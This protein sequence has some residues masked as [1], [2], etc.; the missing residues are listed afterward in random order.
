MGLH[1]GQ[2]T[3]LAAEPR[4]PRGGSRSIKGVGGGG[5][6][7]EAVGVGAHARC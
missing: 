3:V 1:W 2:N 6:L 4:A 7:Q 5:G